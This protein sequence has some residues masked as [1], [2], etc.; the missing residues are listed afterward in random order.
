MLLF[1]IPPLVCC[2]KK[3]VCRLVWTMN[4]GCGCKI[5]EYTPLWTGVCWRFGTRTANGL[6][7]TLLVAPKQSTFLVEFYAQF[8]INTNTRAVGHYPLFVAHF[9][10]TLTHRFRSVL[11]VAFSV[12]SSAV[13]PSAS[14][15]KQKRTTLLQLIKLRRDPIFASSD[16]PQLYLLQPLPPPNNST[17]HPKERH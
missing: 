2:L 16:L 3:S 5:R 8:L 9:P 6:V 14:Q 4:C 7:F 13:E 11:A 12:R 17:D 15:T 1:K 10:R